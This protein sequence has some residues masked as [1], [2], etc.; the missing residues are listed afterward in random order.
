MYVFISREGLSSFLLGA[1]ADAINTMLR[2]AESEMD[3][4]EADEIEYKNLF[5]E[6]Y[7]LCTSTF[8]NMLCTFSTL[9]FS[10]ICLII[11]CLIYILFWLLETVCCINLMP[12]QQNVES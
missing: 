2:A 6:V 5:M 3:N 12:F 11:M 10:K 7:T 4:K 9:E 1:E 8:V